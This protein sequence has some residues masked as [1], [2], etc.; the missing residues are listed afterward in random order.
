[1]GELD[2]LADVAFET[3]NGLLKE[4]LLLVCNPLQGVL[5]L[6]G[7]VGLLKWL[8]GFNGDSKQT[9][10]YAKLDGDGEEVG[11]GQLGNGLTTGY[12]REVDIA[13]LNKAFLALENRA[14]D[15]L[16]EAVMVSVHI[17]ILNAC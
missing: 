7:T 12:T 6:L 16:G 5:G 11:A 2:T 4:S 3:L 13:R 9:C 8:A 10:T 1:M 15:L 14:D 17:K